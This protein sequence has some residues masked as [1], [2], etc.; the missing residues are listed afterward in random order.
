MDNGITKAIDLLEGGPGFTLPDS[1]RKKLTDYG[2]LLSSWNEYA[3]LMAPRTLTEDIEGH[4]TDSLSLVPYLANEMKD[5]TVYIDVGS[6]GGFPAI[7]ITITLPSLST[8]LIE[9]SAKKVSFLQKCVGAL[10]LDNVTVMHAHFPSLDRLDGPFVITARA[11]DKPE[12]LSDGL[13]EWMGEDDLFLCQSR[14][15]A[16]TVSQDFQVELM[17]DEWTIAHLRRGELW[18]IR[19]RA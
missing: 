12:N 3:G 9:R 19:L 8:I 5:E 1:W 7:P 13:L 11:V 17:V 10:S 18:T 6:G 14:A 15:F 4:M 16:D 2:Q